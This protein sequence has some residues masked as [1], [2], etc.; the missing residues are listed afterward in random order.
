MAP[1]RVAGHAGRM[2]RVW[3]VLLAAVVVVGGGAVASAGPAATPKVVGGQ[4]A[5][6]TYG[7]VGA[8][9]RAGSGSVASR[10]FCGGALVAPT[11]VVTAA[12][13]AQ[14][15]Q[16]HPGGLVVLG[17]ADLTG[18]G[19]EEIGFASVTRDPAWSQQADSHDIALLK[20]ER[21]SQQAPVALMTTATSLSAATVA[22]WGYT[23][24]TGGG[25]SS[26]LLSV[27]L[28]VFSDDECARRVGPR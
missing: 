8:L 20:L 22:G 19:G 2:R 24:A 14:E 11:W 10:Q 12:H 26:R 1:R 28:P 21:P 13:C 3:G 23:V 7:F 15:L 27:S 17:R 25:Q 4:P 6:D 18:T 16:L 9:I 5:P